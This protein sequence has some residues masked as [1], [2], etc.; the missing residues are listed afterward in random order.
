MLLVFLN[1][2]LV[3]PRPVLLMLCMDP[4]QSE[5]RCSGEEEVGPHLLSPQHIQHRCYLLLYPMISW[6]ASQPYLALFPF[7][8][9]IDQSSFLTRESHA[10]ELFNF[11]ITADE[12]IVETYS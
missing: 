6:G 3:F 10:V 4:L 9:A 11:K 1:P 8:P 12:D 5:G 2:V 7:R